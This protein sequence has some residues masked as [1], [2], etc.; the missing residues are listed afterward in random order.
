MSAVGGCGAADPNSLWSDGDGPFPP[1]RQPR[2]W[3]T[4]LLAFC[5]RIWRTPRERSTAFQKGTLVCWAS[6]ARPASRPVEP[7]DL[8]HP[9][10]GSP[11]AATD[12]PNAGTAINFFSDWECDNMET[13]SAR[14]TPKRT[15]I[16]GRLDKRPSKTVSP[17]QKERKKKRDCKRRCIKQ[18]KLLN[19]L[20]NCGF[21]EKRTKST[22][23]AIDGAKLIMCVSSSRS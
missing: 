11:P 10:L 1:P 16:V 19:F 12:T 18:E 14:G 3:E 23:N 5:S 15:R 22:P 2:C 8:A 4:L 17:L 7:P 21:P 20:S 9:R 13:L 6:L